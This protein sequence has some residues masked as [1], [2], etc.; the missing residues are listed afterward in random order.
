MILQMTELRQRKAK[1]KTWQQEHS[2]SSSS[3]ISQAADLHCKM[4]DNQARKVTL[5]A[6]YPHSKLHHKAVQPTWLR[7]MAIETISCFRCRCKTLKTLW[8]KKVGN[9]KHFYGIL[10]RGKC[11]GNH[12]YKIMTT[13]LV[14]HQGNTAQSVE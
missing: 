5:Q 8:R 11:S 4:K 7:T 3:N 14:Q 1:N 13:S 2:K 6:A 10:Y 12:R 9:K